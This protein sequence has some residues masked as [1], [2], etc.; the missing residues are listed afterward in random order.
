[1]S[2]AF[3]ADKS[4]TAY[5][6]I[7]LIL[8]AVDTCTK[9][10]VRLD[11]R[12]NM[13][14]FHITGF[15]AALLFVS[16]VTIETTVHWSG[17]TDLPKTLSPQKEAQIL[18]TTVAAATTTPSQTPFKVPS[19]AVAPPTQANQTTLADSA[20]ESIEV[21]EQ[22]QREISS[23][24]V[25][26]DEVRQ[27]EVKR[28]AEADRSSRAASRS[29]EDSLRAQFHDFAVRFVAADDSLAK[30]CAPNP[31]NPLGRLNVKVSLIS[32]EITR[33]ESNEPA[34]GALFVK[35]SEDFRSYDGH[36][37]WQ[38]VW[39]NQFVFER[40]TDGWHCTGGECRLTSDENSTRAGRSQWIGVAIP[41][42]GE[43]WDNLGIR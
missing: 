11:E 28:Q 34:K 29:A 24:R 35:N 17:R 40:R 15:A 37:T 1:M 39:T 43:S 23:Q 5:G 3:A 33:P 32:D 14:R 6:T 18:T 38:R 16:L 4:C 21:I 13:S 9:F 36:I 31:A 26:I 10:G 41:L 12:M 7:G 20:R 2:A 22:L 19:T 8:V 27:N 30:H 25:Q 42:G